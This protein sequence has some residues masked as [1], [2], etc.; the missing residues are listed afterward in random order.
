MFLQQILGNIGRAVV[1]TVKKIG[2]KTTVTIG[3]QNSTPNTS[4]MNNNND[5]TSTPMPE[6]I[7]GIPNMFL[8]IGG[9]VAAYFFLMPK[10]RRR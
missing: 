7:K 3:G 9:A 4:Q 1:N 8:L 5:N 6:I 10:G 2:G